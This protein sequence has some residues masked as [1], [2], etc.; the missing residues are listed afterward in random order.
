[1]RIIILLAVCCLWLQ[2]SRITDRRCMV[3]ENEE[4]DGVALI[5]FHWFLYSCGSPSSRLSTAMAVY[6]STTRLS[7]L[8]PHFFGIWDPFQEGLCSVSEYGSS[9]SLDVRLWLWLSL[10]H[11]NFFLWLEELAALEVS[12]FVRA[13]LWTNQRAGFLPSS[14]TTV[15]DFGLRFARAYDFIIPSGLQMAFRFSCRLVWNATLGR[16][17]YRVNGHER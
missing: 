6:H 1:M 15:V 9:F 11:L 12:F 17:A 5:Y 7:P 2:V 16:S 10:W 3:L 8:H 4:R 13:I 14:L